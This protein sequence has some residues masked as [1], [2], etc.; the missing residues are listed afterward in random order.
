MTCVTNGSKLSL[1]HQYGYLLLTATNSNEAEQYIDSILLESRP[2]ISA[3]TEIELLCW[4][5]ATEKDMDVLNNF[6]GDSFVH[7][8]E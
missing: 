1:G 3:I 2:S 7:E 6:I 8:L 5:T 4:K